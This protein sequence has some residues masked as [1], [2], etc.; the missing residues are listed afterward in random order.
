MALNSANGLVHLNHIEDLVI[1]DGKEGAKIASDTIAQFIQKFKKDAEENNDLTISEKIDG[2]VSLYFGT[3]PDGQFFVGTKGVLSKVQQKIAYSLSDIKRLYQSG[4]ENVLAQAFVALKPAFLEKGMAC[5]GDLLWYNKSGKTESVIDGENLLTFQPNTI[6]YGI[7]VDPKSELFKKAY[8]ANLGIVIHNVYETSYI[9]GDRIDFNRVGVDK[10]KELAEK[11]NRYPNVFCIHP[12]VENL[13][14][15]SDDENVV[16]EIEETLKSVQVSIN[17]ID[18]SFDRDWRK[19]DN[20][21]IKMAKTYLPQFINQQVRSSEEEETILTSKDEKDFL[22]RFKNKFKE[23]MGVKGRLEMDKMK[24]LKGKEQKEESFKN[25]I[26]WMYDYQET[27]EPMFLSFF[28]LLNI[29]KLIIHLLDNLERK[30]GKTFIVNRKNDFDIQAVKPEGY[31]FLSGDHM[32]KIV[33]RMEFSKNNMLYGRFSEESI[34]LL[35]EKQEEPKSII[36]SVVEDVLS[37]MESAKSINDGWNDEQIVEAATNMKNYS[38]IYV[39]RFQPP[40]TA[41]VENIVNLSKLFK[42]VYILVSKT[43]NLSPKYLIN[44]PLSDEE[45]IDLFDSDPKLKLLNNVN[46]KR[47]ATHLVYGLG[48]ENSEIRKTKEGEVRKLL[49]IPQ[50]ETI[51]LTLGKEEHQYEQLKDTGKFFDVRLGQKADNNKKIGI[52]GIDLIP[53][54]DD[55]AKISASTIRKAPLTGDLDT[56]ERYLAGSES[57]KTNVIDEMRDKLKMIQ[58]TL[59]HNK[60]NVLKKEVQEEIDIDLDIISQDE[61]FDIILGVLGE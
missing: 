55:E 61:A 46:I 33:D 45:R 20:Q 54:K 27:F 23:F 59:D 44:N 24:S 39:G 56:A 29:K 8:K 41:H 11:I 4:I 12:Y 49:D 32:V 1:I 10:V 48:S 14:M 34:I 25:F 31:V 15:I 53:S 26:T 9:E 19:G 5:Q 60:K 22:R 35:P 17:M 13:D 36:D 16:Q 58:N 52:Y 43:D 50:E 57:M 47:G 6:M 3:S 21:F 40:T 38:A 37:A 7:T 42:E 2:S 18:S 30:L 28:R 51:V